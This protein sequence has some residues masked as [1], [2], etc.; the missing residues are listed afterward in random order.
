M[1]LPV[2]FRIALRELR[3]GVR[4]FRVFIACLALGVAAVAAVGLVRHSI[5]A[6]L[7][8][9]GATLLGGDAEIQL[10]YRF[11]TDTE[12]GWMEA[13]AATVSEIVDFRS[14]VVVDRNGNTERGLTQVKGVDGAYPIF[15]TVRLQ[16]ELALGKALEGTGALPGSVMDPVLIQRLGLEVGESFRLGTQEFMLSAALLREPDGVG[17]GFGLGPRTIVRTDALAESGL[18]QPGT[19]FDI[20]YRMDVPAEAEL[21]ELEASAN[22]VFEGGLLWRDSRN[23]APGVSEFINRLGAFLVL[24]GLAG[25]AVGGVGVAAAVRSYLDEKINV[26]ATLKTVGAETRTIFMA[27]GLQT[28]ALTLV[29]IAIGLGLG[30]VSAFTLLILAESLLPV[31]VVRSIHAAPLA[32]AALYGALTAALFTL[33]PLAR[34]ERIRAAA[35]FRDRISPKT[36]FPRW[37]FLAA[38]VLILAALVAAAAALSGIPLL[39]L[40]SVAGLVVAFLALLLVAAGLRLAA[41]RL[42]RVRA[43]RQLS[44]LR[45]ALGSIGGAGSEADSVVL[46]LGLGLSVLAAIGQI[47]SNL[48][49]AITQELPDVAPSYFVVDIQTDQLERFIGGLHQ[50]ADVRRVESAPMLRGVITEINGRP[51][52][53]AAGEHWVLQG[54]RGITYSAVPPS[55]TVVTAGSWWPE[56]YNGQPQISFAAEEAAE[57]GLVIG[58]RLT[59]NVLGREIEAEITSFRE[60]D[61]STAG[62]GFILSMNPASLSGAPHSHI[63]TIYAEE[64]AE[65]R[66]LR[67]IGEVYPN[68]TMIRVRDAISR[69]SEILQGVAAA[70]A[71]GALV[72][73][74]TGLVVL[75]G[76]AAAGERARRFEAAVLKTVGA[77]RR[78]ILLGFALRSA[79]FGMTAGA[80]AVGAGGAAGW[81][82]MTF[83]MESGFSFDSVSALAIVLGGTMTTLIAGL[84]FAWGPLSA[85]PAHVLRTSE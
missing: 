74:L 34:T 41:R 49:G 14:M 46:S 59:V 27:Y 39:A 9:E 54:D 37:Q 28:A 15:G 47:D 79:L 56:D 68:I 31:P 53:A 58:D 36:G 83:V 76:A 43:V 44:A 63:A 82:V 62:I 77:S 84:A 78:A 16:P 65:A 4:G 18:L 3:G 42:A 57:L 81:A 32:E 75:I 70:T 80:V 11:A 48:R 51:A 17:G 8:Q 67:E 72:S 61:F 6:G 5:E 13:N 12:R 1:S 2:A 24:V 29:G 45:R 35:L 50:D 23:A 19:L 60:V 55:G 10:S 25:L 71:C 26:I 22:E 7:K 20:S 64:S 69:V 38:L 52:A 73:L 30:S 21:M 66:L 40:W 85:R 33:W